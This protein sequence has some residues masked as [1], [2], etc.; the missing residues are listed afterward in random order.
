MSLKRGEAS[1][2][3]TNL[4]YKELFNLYASPNIIRIFRYRVMR[5]IEHVARS[6]EEY[7]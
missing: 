5:L 4:K 6:G 7:A 1:K 2:D 3:W